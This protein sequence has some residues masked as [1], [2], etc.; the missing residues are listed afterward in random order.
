MVPYSSPFIIPNNSLHNPFLHPLRRTRQK[1][2]ISR[3]AGGAPGA[4]GG[5]LADQ[6]L[7]PVGRGPHKLGINGRAVIRVWWFGV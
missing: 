7:R 1:T 5:Y 2:G 6:S 3:E 4:L